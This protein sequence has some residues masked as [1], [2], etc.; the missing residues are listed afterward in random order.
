MKTR[1]ILKIIALIGLLLFACVTTTAT[2]TPELAGEESLPDVS[3]AT[4]TAVPPTDTS[5]P[6]PTE[7]PTTVPTDTPAPTETATPTPDLAATEAFEATQQA[8]AAQE[9]VSEVLAMAELTTDSG[10]LAWIQERAISVVSD[11]AWTTEIDSIDNGV[12]YESYVLNIDTTWETTTGF[13][14][15]GIIFHSDDNLERGKQYRFYTLRL[16]GLPGWDVELWNYGDWQSTT[17]GGVK[18]NSVIDQDNDATNNYTLVVRKGLMAA[19]ANGER[20][21]N[22]IISTMNKGRIGLFAWQESGKSTCTYENGWIW[23]LDGE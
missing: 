6:E 13:A 16:S 10:H 17:T 2:P 12:V 23:V 9:M 15:C 19:Y 3:T 7:I 20:L 11:V 14:G 8:E 22:V 21:S 18:Y 1:T 4:D 5:T